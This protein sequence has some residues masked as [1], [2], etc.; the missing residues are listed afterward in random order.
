[1]KLSIA[2]CEGRWPVVVRP[3]VVQLVTD[4]GVVT[5]RGTDGNVMVRLPHA[6]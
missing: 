6:H 2:G 3:V 5:A 4:V 1:V